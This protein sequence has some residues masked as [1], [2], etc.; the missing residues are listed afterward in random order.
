MSSDPKGCAR[1]NFFW[2]KESLENRSN[3]FVLP[4]II[5]KRHI[6]LTPNI[7]QIVQNKFLGTLHIYLDK[8][9]LGHVDAA[10]LQQSGHANGLNVV[11]VIRCLLMDL[12]SAVVGAT[13]A[14]MLVVAKRN[15][16]AVAVVDG[17][18]NNCDVCTISIDVG[19]EVEQRLA[20]GF[21]NINMITLSSRIHARGPDPAPNVKTDG[22]WAE[23][24][25]HDLKSLRLQA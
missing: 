9:E 18:G 10:L 17:A 14:K 23:V 16:F 15:F 5:M 21:D 8:R 20:I 22:S 19:L 25:V 7:E 24:S 1:I 2:L 12:R 6:Q 13:L 4:P 3:I 11:S